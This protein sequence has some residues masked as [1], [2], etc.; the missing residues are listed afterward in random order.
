MSYQALGFTNLSCGPSNPPGCC[1]SSGVKW[2]KNGSQSTTMVAC[3]N[4]DFFMFDGSGKLLAKE[5]ASEVEGLFSGQ[6]T[7]PVNVFSSDTLKKMAA[8]KSQDPASQTIEPAMSDSTFYWGV[9]AL[10][11]MI[12]V[13]AW[14]AY[15]R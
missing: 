7:N 6:A 14:Y 2:V 9:A 11:A 8:S 10:V 1:G 4:D 5:K 3:N 12:G 15:R 13:G